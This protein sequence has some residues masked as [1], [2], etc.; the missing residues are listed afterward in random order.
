M[1]NLKV[2]SFHGFKR[3]SEPEEAIMKISPKMKP[4]T[5][6][7]LWGKINKEFL[8]AQE[9]D[10]LTFRQP[11]E[12]N[13]RLASWDPGEKS[14][15]WYRTFL[16]LAYSTSSSSVQKSFQN[17]AMKMDIG[18]PVSNE[19]SSPTNKNFSV[20]LD[21][22]LAFEEFEY[23]ENSIVDISSIRRIVEIGA[24]FGRTAHV[25][26]EKLEELENYLIFDL[27]EM[28]EVSRNYLKSTLSH[29]QFEKISFTSSLDFDTSP[30]FDLGIQIDGFQEMPTQTIDLIYSKILSVSNYVYLQNPIGKYLPESA[31]LDV[32]FQEIPFNLGRSLEVFDIWNL[33]EV[34]LHYKAHL[35]AYRPISHELLHSMPNRLFPHYLH[36]IYLNDQKV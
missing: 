4:T 22:L 9:F 28:L 11:G 17:L 7:K 6:S 13:S 18:N 24:G 3:F 32:K 21:Y 12:L 10:L 19:Q 14:L 2:P 34:N 35:E 23:L 5:H 25:L 15:R 26:I 29:K 36:S 1:K 8:G 20:N 27:P 33:S 30:Y 16:N 31:G